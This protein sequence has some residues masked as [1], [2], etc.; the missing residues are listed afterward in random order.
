[1]TSE[2]L[3]KSDQMLCTNSAYLHYKDQAF[4]DFMFARQMRHNKCP[5]TQ[6]DAD[7]LLRIQPSSRL[8][9]CESLCRPA[10]VA[11]S[12]KNEFLLDPCF[13]PTYQNYMVYDDEKMCTK[14]HQVLN[15]VTRRR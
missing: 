8:A 14:L 11:S 10:A 9:T 6:P 5:E 1:M 13:K 2:S 3:N 15:N 7:G 4:N 12:C